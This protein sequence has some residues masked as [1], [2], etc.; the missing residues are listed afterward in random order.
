[1]LLSEVF[2]GRSLLSSTLMLPVFT[3]ILFNFSS[4]SLL[5]LGPNNE[6]S[7]KFK[8]DLTSLNEVFFYS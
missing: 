1:M 7:L 8:C 5:F 3:K 4:Y 2:R 6:L